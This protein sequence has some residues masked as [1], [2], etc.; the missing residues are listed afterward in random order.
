MPPD[1]KRCG[2]LRASWRPPW[3]STPTFRR[4]AFRCGQQFR[5][6][7]V[8][9]LCFQGYAQVRSA[10]ELQ[11]LIIDLDPKTSR[12]RQSTHSAWM[13]SL[14]LTAWRHSSDWLHGQCVSVLGS[15]R[16]VHVH[17]A[18]KS[19]GRI[20]IISGPWPPQTEKTSTTGQH[21]KQTHQNRKHTHASIGRY[22][23]TSE[24]QAFEWPLPECAFAQ[25]GSFRP[26]PPAPPPLAPV[27]ATAAETVP[28]TTQAVPSAAASAATPAASAP[29]AAGD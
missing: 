25:L 3:R 14:G 17:F 8:P 13:G 9:S 15:G 28:C 20:I 1:C 12:S 21:N 23:Y 19:R 10:R 16:N 5:F 22:T 27:S 4:R 6:I 7:S 29:A 24:A 18:G 26:P 11:Q 2:R